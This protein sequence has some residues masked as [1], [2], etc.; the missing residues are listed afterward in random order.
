MLWLITLKNGGCFEA[1]TKRQIIN[2][3]VEISIQKNLRPEIEAIFIMK[4]NGTCDE[5][6]KKVISKIQEI[7]DQK[8]SESLEIINQESRG[9]RAIESEFFQNL[10]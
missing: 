3:I 5:I 10:I 6:C 4:K 1:N 9:Q 2:D 7:V 8:L